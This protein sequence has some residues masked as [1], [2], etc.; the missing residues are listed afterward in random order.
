MK[1]RIG[2]AR[3]STRE[4][5]QNSKAL[6]QQIDRIAPYVDEI[7]T[8]VESGRSDTRTSFKK[9]EKMIVAGQVSMLVVTRLDRLSRSL[10]TLRKFIDILNKNDCEIKAL[11]NSI[12]T[13]SAAGKFHISL[14]GAL[15]EMESDQI[16]ERVKHGLNFLIKNGRAFHA[17]FGYKTQNYKF[18]FD[19]EPFLCSLSS[20]IEWSRHEIAIALIDQYLKSASLTS[21]SWWLKDFFDI[22]MARSSISRWFKNPVLLGHT[23]F[24]STGD[25]FYDQHEPITEIDKLNEVHRLLS[26]NSRIGGWKTTKYNLSGLIYCGCGH[27][28]HIEQREH[29]YLYVRCGL[30]S[31]CQIKTKSKAYKE[32]ENQVFLALVKQV[33][34]LSFS[35]F[36]QN[37]KS[38]PFSRL[39][40]ELQQLELIQNPHRSIVAAIAELK[41]E[42]EQEKYILSKQEENLDAK[43]F[44]ETFS[45]PLFWEFFETRDLSERQ[46]ILRRFIKK[47]VFNPFSVEFNI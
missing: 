47:V 18:V 5:S 12:D 21:V 10:L 14:L 30:R 37:T 24:P 8:D 34:T 29:I 27:K 16:S 42:I 43:L 41:K 19:S 36:S 26:F 23:H 9:I 40:S 15:A 25:I 39:Q 1:K 6:E 3:V 33:E 44:V 17:P 31:R 32:I 11:D 20:K 13:A 4:Q 35:I 7:L 46:S 2:Y 45:H 22:Q 38:P 28:A